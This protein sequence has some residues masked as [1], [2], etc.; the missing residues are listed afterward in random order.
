MVYRGKGCPACSETGYRGRTAI[1]EI[2]IVS[3]AIRLLILKKDDSTSICRQALEEG[4]KTLR[5]DG[6]QEVIAG[7]TTLE[8]VARVTQE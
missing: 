5:D 8:E 6:A 3:D 4:M 2:L 1:Y 7:V